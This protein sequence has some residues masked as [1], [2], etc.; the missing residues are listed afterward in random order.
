M[1]DMIGPFSTNILA[2]NENLFERE[3]GILGRRGAFAE[4]SPLEP[5]DTA[6]EGDVTLTSTAPIDQMREAG[7]FEAI[8]GFQEYLGVAAAADPS[9][10]DLH[11][12]D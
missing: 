7:H 9:I 12:R 4:G 1:A 3:I 6:L 11:D 10:L 5:P 8:M 2:G